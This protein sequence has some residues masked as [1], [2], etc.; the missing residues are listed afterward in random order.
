MVL[1]QCS[2]NRTET[3]T[4]N[5]SHQ[6]Y[7]RHFS[8]LWENYEHEYTILLIKTGLYDYSMKRYLHAFLNQR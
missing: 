2:K 1:I 4:S 3:D 8:G 5:W 7:D 6:A